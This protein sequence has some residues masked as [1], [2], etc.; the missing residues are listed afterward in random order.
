MVA[1]RSVRAGEGG[2]SVA[3]GVCSAAMRADGAAALTF[4]TG[5]LLVFGSR[6]GPVAQVV[7]AH[8]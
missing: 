8:A 5:V 4:G 7:R 2:M 3:A 1:N 6:V